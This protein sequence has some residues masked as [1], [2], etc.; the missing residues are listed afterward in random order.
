M[1]GGDLAYRLGERRGVA[2]AEVHDAEALGIEARLRE[3][4]PR[5]RHASVGAPLAVEVVAAARRAGDHQHPVRALLERD[6]Q[7]QRGHGAR[8]RH[9]DH[10]HRGRV[11]D[12]PHARH[13]GRHAAAVPARE[14]RQLGS[15]SVHDAVPPAA[16]QRPSSPPRIA[17]AVSPLVELDGPGRA[18]RGARAAPLAPGRVDP[19]LAAGHTGR[20]RPV[21]RAGNAVGA[22]AYAGQAVGAEL[23]VDPGHGP[24]VHGAGPR[25]VNERRLRR[26]ERLRDRLGERLRSGGEAA[27]EDARLEG[28][29][30]PGLRLPLA[31]EAIGA[32]PDAEAGRGAR[33]LGTR[34][35]RGGEH[36]EVG[37]EI[38]RLAE[39]RVGHRRPAGRRRAGRST[40]GRA[41]GSKR[42]NST[43]AFRAAV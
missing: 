5:V 36:Q 14:H 30:G 34:Q 32:E 25:Q 8:A 27:G 16:S 23:R 1:R 29:G 35:H 33:A 22:G 18:L 41:R 40:S 7:L 28:A 12:A 13:L 6:Q 39:A 37:R 21:A 26:R 4:R 10:L 19:R 2:D 24:G 11:A 43:P 31:H 17:T 9:V 15:S 38:E 42:A 20:E 3:G